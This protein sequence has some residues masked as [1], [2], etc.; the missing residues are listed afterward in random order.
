MRKQVF[1]FGVFLM[2]SLVFAQYNP[3]KN[4]D[5]SHF[6]NT[7]DEPFTSEEFHPKDEETAVLLSVLTPVAFIGLGSLLI[8]YDNNFAGG[9]LI[10]GGIIFAPS[11]G[12]F[13]AQNVES[14]NKGIG[15]RLLGSAM[16]LGGAYLV[17]ADGLSRSYGGGGNDIVGSGGTILLLSGT[18]LVFYSTVYDIFNSKRSVQTYNE[19]KG[20][21][22][23]TVSPA[24]YPEFGSA[25]LGVSINF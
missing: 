14:V 16:T 7:F 2:P 20:Q 13:Y 9:M 19:N 25:G 17:I 21:V 3:L 5:F 10:G 18:G 23:Y 12:N 4:G 22:Y 11:A 1:L 15:T 24:Y 8:K 6:T